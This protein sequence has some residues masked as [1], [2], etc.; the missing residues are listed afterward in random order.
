MAE[1]RARRVAHGHL[2]YALMLSLK[3]I[4]YYKEFPGLASFAWAN[5]MSNILMVA[6]SIKSKQPEN[7][8]Q[9]VLV[10]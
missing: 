5:C 8:S 2:V 7:Y 1:L 10:L 4:D 3:N 6:N 9:A